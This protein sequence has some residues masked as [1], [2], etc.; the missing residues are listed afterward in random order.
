MPWV[1]LFSN[2]FWGKCLALA[3]SSILGWV[4]PVQLGRIRA[5]LALARQQIAEV[6]SEGD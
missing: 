1:G 5:I 2:G 4:T 6:L 3:T